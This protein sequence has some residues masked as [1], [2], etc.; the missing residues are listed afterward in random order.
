[1]KFPRLVIAVATL[2]LTLPLSVH[3]AKDPAKKEA[4]RATRDLFETYDKNHNGS[5]EGEE[6][7]V[8]KKAYESAKIG[9]LKQFDT[10]GDG[11]LSDSEI[12]SVKAPKKK[13]G[14]GLKKKK[15]A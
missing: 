13:G 4:K 10:N 7:E 2:A 3:A 14:K 6:A 1:M 12:A 11:K 8:L 5:I 15:T 9:P